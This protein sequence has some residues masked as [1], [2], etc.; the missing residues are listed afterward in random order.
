MKMKK[1]YLPMLLCGYMCTLFAAAPQLAVRPS[2]PFSG[3]LFTFEIILDSD[4]KFSLK[5]PELPDGLRVS[6]NISSS[7]FN[8]TVINGKRTA[9]AVYG[10]AAMADKPGKYTIA[11]F[12]LDINGKKVQTNK[13]EITVRDAA[14]RERL[15]ASFNH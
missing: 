14:P 4:E 7:S 3:E 1:L 15:L 12:T 9:T 13:L 2:R 5:L 11:P 8:T 6:K 10:V